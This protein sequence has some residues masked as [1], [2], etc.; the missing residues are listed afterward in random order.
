[1][2]VFV[3]IVFNALDLVRIYAIRLDGEGYSNN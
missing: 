3:L 2:C 1:M